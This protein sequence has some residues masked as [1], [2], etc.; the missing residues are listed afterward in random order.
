MR[1][2][3]GY[4]PLT[5][6]APVIAAAELGFAREEGIDLVLS[7]EPSWATLRDRLALGHL[8]AAHML[9]PLA[10]ATRLG[11][12]G[13]QA[14]LVAPMALNLNGNAITV[15][16]PLWEAMAPE[17]DDLDAVASA[18]ARLAMARAGE[19][20]PLTI[21]TVHPFSCHSY[22]LRIFAER[23]GLD[24]GRAVRIVVV[25]P[26]QTVDALRRG[27]IDGFCVGAPWNSI[28]VAAGLGRIAAL[29]CEIVPDCP[30][31]VLAVHG[32]QA[33]ALSP[34]VE[35][36]HRAGT[37]CA[38]PANVGE[39]AGLL[40]EKGGLGPDTDLIRRTL[41]GHLVVDPTGLCRTAPDYLRL[42]SSVHRPR[43]E[44]RAWLARQMAA[45]GQIADATEVC[46]EAE[47][48]YR[49]SLLKA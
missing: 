22:Q 17:A 32:S 25:P 37:W 12:S 46:E 44:H 20:R 28:A 24:L 40:S 14:D 3:L 7:P 43:P 26:P 19:G 9:A 16:L 45:S 23:G 38:D 6:A 18:F 13:P 4:V 33:E 27:E 42:G 48:F 39:L 34:L 29:G 49:P 1:V 21:A 8:D 35:A 41:T 47:A 10:L 11:L 2:D 5:D 15:S 30:E 36:L 31:K